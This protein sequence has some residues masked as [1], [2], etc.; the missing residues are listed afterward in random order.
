M[1]VSPRG[2]RRERKH[3][4]CPLASDLRPVPSLVTQ[5]ILTSD[6]S[7]NWAPKFGG[8]QRADDL[9][10]RQPLTCDLSPK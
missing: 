7:P 5:S 10:V 4:T 8:D 9:A 6:L 3:A 2:G 1:G